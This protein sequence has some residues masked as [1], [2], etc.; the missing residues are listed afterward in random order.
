ME[1]KRRETPEER[2]AKEQEIMLVSE[3]LKRRFRSE[4][5]NVQTTHSDEEF[6]EILRGVIRTDVHESSMDLLVN[7]PFGMNFLTPYN[8]QDAKVH[9]IVRAEKFPIDLLKDELSHEFANYEVERRWGEE[10]RKFQEISQDH[11]DRLLDEYDRRTSLALSPLERLKAKLG[12]Q[13]LPQQL[14]V[15][16]KLG[17]FSIWDAPTSVPADFITV[18]KGLGDRLVRRK[19]RKIED[20]AKD[21]KENDYA[22]RV[23]T[24]M[25]FPYMAY[26][27]FHPDDQREE[28]RLDTKLRILL[29]DIGYRNVLDDVRSVKRLLHQ[30]KVPIDHRN[31]FEVLLKVEEVYF[32]SLKE[33]G[34]A[35]AK[36]YW[37]ILL[38]LVSEEQKRPVTRSHFEAKDE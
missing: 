30:I 15:L 13:G 18:E 38:D 23:F 3:D 6:G 17:Y 28:L 35:P 4:D 20:W 1:T 9:V 21:A 14:I 2:I 11:L 24:S 8:T 32:R 12:V 26:A 34:P 5:L 16:L 7:S 10:R 19:T 37:G 36:E 22:A 31:L 29:T 27:T 25:N 33:K